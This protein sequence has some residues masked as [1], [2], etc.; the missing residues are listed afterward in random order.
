MAGLCDHTG[1][2]RPHTVAPAPASFLLTSDFWILPK[3]AKQTQSTLPF[4]L[5]PL[6]FRLSR[7]QQPAPPNLP[8]QPPGPT[9]KMR[10]KPNCHPRVA[11]RASG[12]GAKRSGPKPRDLFN[13]HRQRRFQTKKP[14]SQQKMRNEPNPAPSPSSRAAGCGAKRSSPKSRDLFNHHRQRRFQT[15]KLHPRPN[16]CETNPIYRPASIAPPPFMRNEPNYPTV[17]PQP[18]QSRT[19]SLR[20]ASPEKNWC[21]ETNPIPPPAASLPNINYPLKNKYWR[22]KTGD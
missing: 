12:C 22:L 4:L 17:S 16:F 8:P 3:N 5:S 9:P 15:K 19:N 18:M 6:Y 10:N 7:G 13:H 14:C 20:C 2:G 21:E 1:Q 11:S